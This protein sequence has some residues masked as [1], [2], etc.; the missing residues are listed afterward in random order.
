MPTPS[1]LFTSLSVEQQIELSITGAAQRSLS[2]HDR[3]HRQGLAYIWKN[4]QGKTPEQVFAILGPKGKKLVIGSAAVGDYLEFQY[5]LAGVPY[6]KP[7]LPFGV[8][9]TFNEDD[10]VKVNRNVVV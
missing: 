6:T 4:P 7:A 3:D 1:P 10:S 2:S 5:G 9:L 8:T